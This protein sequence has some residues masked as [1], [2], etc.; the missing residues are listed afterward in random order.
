[1][2]S[3][4]AVAYPQQASGAVI[5][6]PSGSEA[7]WIIVT[8]DGR[9]VRLGAEAGKLFQC[10]DGSS[11]IE[12]LAERMGEPWTPATVSAGVSRLRQSGLI[13]EAGGEIRRKPGRFRAPSIASLQLT[14]LD[15]PSLFSGSQPWTTAVASG[16]SVAG[17]LSIGIIGLLALFVNAQRVVTDLSTP[18]S[19]L[20]AIVL[21]VLM[22]FLASLHELGHAVALAHYGGAVRRIGVMLLYLSPA[23]F[24]DVSDAWSLREKRQR[25]MVALAGSVMSFALAGGCAALYVLS[26]VGNPLLAALAVASYASVIFNLLPFVKFDG[27]IALMTHLDVPNLRRIAMDDWKRSL[28]RF[29]ACA[30]RG[31]RRPARRW[32]PWYGL[33]CS[34]MPLALLGSAAV[35]FGAVVAGFGGVGM[36][37]RSTI[38][39]C[40]GAVALRGAWR[41][42]ELSGEMD[43]PPWTTPLLLAIAAAGVFAVSL[44]GVQP[45]VSTGYA[46]LADGTGALVIPAGWQ[47]EELAE[48]PVTLLQTGLL[49]RVE[50]GDA[51]SGTDIGYASMPARAMAL[52]LRYEG[53]E[54]VPTLSL[55]GVSASASQGDVGVAQIHLGTTPMIVW[56]WRTIVVEPVRALS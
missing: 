25:V 35:Q 27:Y 41:F 32:L 34:L 17:G 20:T 23:M 38:W 55:N 21:V 22:V 33:G 19:P 11:T 42:L 29:V 30:D 40:I 28:L 50:A 1:M 4:D 26:P 2:N 45:H 12:M 31:H 53:A 44:I 39:L 56:A 43:V 15:H 36:I 18:A 9:T 47:A 14:I 6:R 49:W 7:R 52:A 54:A 48:R 24:C 13:A 37:L 5:H 8:P 10:L 46:I 3:D 51:T 16:W